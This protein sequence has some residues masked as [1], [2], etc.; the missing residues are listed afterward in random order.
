M[1]NLQMDAASCVDALVQAFFI[2]SA[3]T[4][5]LSTGMS[6]DSH[7]DSVAHT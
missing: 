7:I 4:N 6:I 2:L 5:L 3:V 1:K